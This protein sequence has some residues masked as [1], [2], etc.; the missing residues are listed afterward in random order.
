[1]EG[2]F[3]R[4]TILVIT[5][6]VREGGEKKLLTLEFHTAGI[7]APVCSYATYRLSCLRI[8]MM[9]SSKSRV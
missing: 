7:P 3:V 9:F 1:M 4:A 5:H 6:K 8:V 2:Y